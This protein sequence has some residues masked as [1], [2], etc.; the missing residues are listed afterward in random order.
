MSAPA[1][2]V[3]PPGAGAG[4]GAG[5]GQWWHLCLL[6]PPGTRLEQLRPHHQRLQLA[7]RGPSYGTA[8]ISGTKKLALVRNPSTRGAVLV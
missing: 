5:V 3:L 2:A 8:A 7:E 6:P 1:G 4:A